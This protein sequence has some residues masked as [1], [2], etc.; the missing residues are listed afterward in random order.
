MNKK[1]EGAIPFRKGTYTKMSTPGDFDSIATMDSM[2]K[3]MLKG[4]YAAI[5][6]VE[7][8][9]DFLASYSPPENQ[10]FMFVNPVPPMLQKIQDAILDADGGHSGASYGWTL[11]QIEYIAKNGWPAFVDLWDET[12]QLKRKLA[13]LEA[14]NAALRSQIKALVLPKKEMTR[15]EKIRSALA[16]G[17]TGGDPCE[18]C[19]ARK[20]MLVEDWEKEKMAKEDKPSTPLAS[21]LQ[22]LATIGENLAK[23]GITNPSPLDMAEASRNVPGFE[24]QADAMKRFAEGK[25]SYA[26]MRSLCG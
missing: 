18:G 11:R 22:N 15:E 3:D 13:K 7:G 5:S 12:K 17:C 16:K 14:D 9:W 6:S 23:A 10:G 8:G 26:E 19:L 25:M 2:S 24:G 1:I 21:A 20:N 4:A